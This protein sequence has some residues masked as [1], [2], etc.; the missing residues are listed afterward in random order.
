MA[1]DDDGRDHGDEEQEAAHRDDHRRGQVHPQR[2]HQV[3]GADGSWGQ[4]QLLS[5]SKSFNFVDQ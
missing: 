5:S 1:D 4:I 3:P 2:L